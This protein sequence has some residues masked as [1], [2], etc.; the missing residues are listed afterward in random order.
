LEQGHYSKQ[1]VLEEIARFVKSRWVG[2]HCIERDSRGNR[3]MIRYV[4]GKPIVVD[5]PHDLLLLMQRL[6]RRGLRSVYATAAVY[7][8]LSSM[9]DAKS[10]SNMILYTPTWDV[11][12]DFEDWR[13][14]IKAC[15][16]V[17]EAL[18]E[19]GIEKSVFV[20][21]SGDGA[22]V[23]LHER[24]ISRKSLK[25]RTPL[26][27]AYAIVEYVRMKVE[28]RIYEI[29]MADGCN[30]RVENKIDRQR[31]FTCPLSLHRDHDRVCVCVRPSNLRHFDPSW[32]DPQ[33]YVHDKSWSSYEEG[34]A[35]ELAEKAMSIVG[36]LPLSRARRRKYPRL[37]EAIAR[38]L[39]AVNDE[40][41]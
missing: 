9:D 10:L 29:A 3:I 7:S 18:K 15:M 6:G 39:S 4:D 37:D 31:M 16:E 20:K 13:S 30:I 32:V 8:K 19:E 1:E 21:W 5:S 17:V 22:H 11:D 28:P 23:H 24:S 2:V 33:N 35:D 40:D 36:G 12:N 26:D 34:E 38:W 25:G 41:R 27:V 14:T